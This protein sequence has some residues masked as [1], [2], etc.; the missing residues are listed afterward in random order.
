[1]WGTRHKGSKPIFENVAHFKY[2][3]MTVK[4][5]NWIQEDIK[6]TLNSG[7]VCYPCL[8]STNV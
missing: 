6:G 4:K 8:L 2:F 1:M 5:K 7:N 3:G